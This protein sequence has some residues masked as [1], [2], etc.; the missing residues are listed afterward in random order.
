MNFPPQPA[1]HAGATRRVD[2]RRQVDTRVR[3][4]GLGHPG[5]PA[6]DVQAGDQDEQADH[7]HREARAHAEQGGADD[8]GR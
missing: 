8:E 1:P 4:Q 3:E 7:H 5:V 6:G 2:G